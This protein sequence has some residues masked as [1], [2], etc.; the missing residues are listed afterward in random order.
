MTF[1]VGFEPNFQKEAELE[2]EENPVISTSE[3]PQIFTTFSMNRGPT[4][5]VLD[6]LSTE[7][8]TLN[9]T[10]SS[11]SDLTTA[12]RIGIDWKGSSGFI[13]NERSP[14][15]IG[16][17]LCAGWASNLRSSKKEIS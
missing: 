14:F 3:S 15:T 8:S 9:L 4:D 12:A 1:R 10:A 7:E 2:I 6:I 16:D 13:E 11:F 5:E 17:Y